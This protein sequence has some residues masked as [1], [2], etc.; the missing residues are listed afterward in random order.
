[1]VGPMVGIVGL[2]NMGGA[3]LGRLVECDLAVKGCDADPARRAAARVAGATPVATPAE[4]ADALVLL[5][6]P[7][8]TAVAAVLAALLPEPA[9]GSTASGCP[10][11]RPRCG[12]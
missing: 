9:A 5:S 2:G 12:R 4:A 10:R 8:A 3:M 7:D 6:L 1:M 11:A